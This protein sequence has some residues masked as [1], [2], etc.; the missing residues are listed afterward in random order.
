[1]KRYF[2]KILL[3]IMLL[4]TIGTIQE[5]DFKFV[6]DIKTI[7]NNLF[8][9]N[10]YNPNVLVLNEIEEN[11]TLGANEAV[12]VDKLPTEEGVLDKPIKLYVMEKYNVYNT[13]ST[14][15]F[16][17]GNTNKIFE[18]PKCSEIYV[19]EIKRVRKIMSTE[20]WYKISDIAEY[21]VKMSDAYASPTI[22]ESCYDEEGNASIQTTT[23]P[24]PTFEVSNETFPEEPYQKMYI[25]KLG[26]IVATVK[27]IKYL[28]DE[29]LINF[30]IKIK[31]GEEEVSGKFNISSA[32]P[33]SD[34]TVEFEIDMKEGEKYNKGNYTIEINYGDVMNSTP[35]SLSD[36]FYFF[37]VDFFGDSNPYY[38]DMNEWKIVVKDTDNFEK[39]QIKDIDVSVEEYY[40]Y[41]GYSGWMDSS[42]FTFELNDDGWSVFNKDGL[43]QAAATK[44]RI[45]VEYIN[46]DT[47]DSRDEPLRY[48]Y[49]FSMKEPDYDTSK[50]ET[51]MHRYV[52][53]STTKTYSNTITRVIIQPGSNYIVYND[54]TTERRDSYNDFT[55]T[56]T[57]VT[58][59]EN[60]LQDEKMPSGT[61]YSF[62]Y[63]NRGRI[64]Y[65][66]D[67]IW[68][69]K[70]IEG[71]SV[72][73]YYIDPTTLGDSVAGERVIEMKDVPMAD[74]IANYG[75][76]SSAIATNPYYTIT[77]TGTVNFLNSGTAT[78]TTK[79][80]NT[81]ENKAILAS[82]GGKVILDAEVNIQKK[83]LYGATL[84]IIDSQGND[85]TN[86]AEFLDLK[87]EITEE[88]EE[89]YGKRKTI[90]AKKLRISFIVLGRDGIEGDYKALIKFQGKAISF[91]FEI[92]KSTIDF[93][94]RAQRDF[95]DGFDRPIPG[96][97]KREW[98]LGIFLS[99]GSDNKIHRNADTVSPR[100]YNRRVDIG[101]N[102]EMI[103]YNLR[104]YQINITK[105]TSST[106]SY[107]PIIDNVQ[108]EEKTDESYSEFRRK[109][110]EA[111]E[112]ID[113]GTVTFDAEGNAN[114]DNPVHFVI[115]GKDFAIS[116]LYFDTTENI[117]KL[118]FTVDGQHFDIAYTE[119]VR[120]YSGLSLIIYN[121]VSFDRDGKALG[122]SVRGSYKEIVDDGKEVTDL[123]N[124]VSHEEEATELNEERAVSITPKTEVPAGEYYA[125]IDYGSYRGLGYINN[126]AD[127]VYS[128]ESYPQLWG[129]NIHMAAFSYVDPVYSFNILNPTFSNEADDEKVMYN[130]VIGTASFNVYFNNTYDFKDTVIHKVYMC[131]GANCKD[132]RNT[133]I[134]VSTKFEANSIDN[135]ENINNPDISQDDRYTT[136]TI[137]NK[138]K[139]IDNGTYI[140]ELIY[141]RVVDENAEEAEKYSIASA[142]QSFEISQ[143]YIGA[144]PS[145]ADDNEIFTYIE[146]SL[147]VDVEASYL[148]SNASI[149]PMIIDSRGGIYTGDLTSKTIKDLDGNVVFNFDYTIEPISTTESKYRYTIKN[150]A[151]AIDAGKYNLYFI[152][153]SNGRE[154]ETN[155]IEFEAITPVPTIDMSEPSEDY[156]STD[157][158]YIYI[159]KNITANFIADDEIDDIKYTVMHFE[160]NFA[161]VD[162]SSDNASNKYAYVSV[163]WDENSRTDT[164]I[165]GEMTIRL[166]RNKADLAAEVADYVIRAEHTGM[167]NP[168]MMTLPAFDN[169]FD[170]TVNREDITISGTYYDE[171]YSSKTNEFY[172]DMENLKIEV[173]LTT[174]Y[175]TNINWAITNSQECRSE[176]LGFGTLCNPNN[177]LNDYFTATN[178]TS[179]NGK[180]LLEYKS[181]SRKLSTG[182]YYLVL[183][184]E[185]NV[186]DRAIIPLT[187]NQKYMNID[188]DQYLVYSDAGNSTIDGLFQNKDG[189][190]YLPVIIT[191][192]SPSETTVQITDING[193]SLSNRPFTFDENTYNSRG[194]LDIKYRPNQ[195][196]ADAK[197]YMIIVSANE[198]SSVRR[199]MSFTMNSTYFNYSMG[200]ANYDPVDGLIPNS[201]TGGEA[202]FIVQTD[203]MSD[204]TEMRSRLP[205]N[206]TIKNSSGEDVTSKFNITS[207]SVSGSS[208]S[209]FLS[210]KYTKDSNIEPG[211]YQVSNNYTYGGYYL[212][213]TASFVIGSYD[214]N[215][216]IDDNIQIFSSTNDNRVHRNV[217]GTYRISYS[218][219]YDLSEGY[220]YIRITDSTGNDITDKFTHQ[221]TSSYIDVNY[222]ANPELEKGTYKVNVYYNEKGKVVSSSINIIL[223]TDFNSIVL[224]NMVSHPSSGNTL[225]YSDLD[226]Q[227]YSFNVNTSAIKVPNYTLVPE[228]LDSNG[229]D[230]TDKFSITDSG[231]SYN[232]TIKAFSAKVDTYSVRLYVLDENGDP[233]YSNALNFTIDENYYNL[234]ILSSSEI[235][236]INNYNDDTTSIYDKDGANV[237]YNFSTDYTGDKKISVI[238]FKDGEV[239]KEFSEYSDNTFN[240]NT[241][242]LDIGKYQVSICIN[243][244]PYDSKNMNVIEYIELEDIILTV[245]NAQI[246]TNNFDVNMGNNNF[247]IRI[248]PTNATASKYTISSS[249]T[250]ILNINGNRLVGV[251]DGT[252]N[253]VIKNAAIE[254]TYQVRVKQRLSSSVYEIDHNV[255]TIYVKTRTTKNFTKTEAAR[256]LSGLVSNY[257]ITNAQNQTVNTNLI[258]TGYHLVNGD[259]TYT[260]IVIGDV[261]GDGNI[262]I[263][264]VAWLYQKVRNKRK[265]NSYQ[266]KA[267][268]IRKATNINAVDIAWLYSFVNRKRNSI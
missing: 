172:E 111:A 211:V 235:K 46:N 233:N 92:G 37:D 96:N 105:K 151:R 215:I 169:L 48:T 214:K 66:Y 190:I 268:K 228:I 65:H 5:L 115:G 29:D 184:Y 126:A 108:L 230:V 68:V 239:I 176:Y 266:T 197:E 97:S 257:R 41:M 170:W 232:I 67:N 14:G 72:S 45:I 260:F 203:G 205:Q 186:E 193:N 138:E 98:F 110:P 32:L 53:S 60:T 143:M 250:S 200:V 103:F 247:T 147:A 82:T 168:A 11:T 81:N 31:Q 2:N 79:T 137:T 21:Y 1:M 261:T 244:I 254:K 140:Y 33:K 162:I 204:I 153:D 210:I 221:I 212:E 155:K 28:K 142:T 100:I 63:D 55:K 201:P 224:S 157:D 208:S 91:P 4:L 54:G 10:L 141:K 171:E 187:I 209:F 225:I 267:A 27:N 85:A 9:T 74:F 114:T 102:G 251:R 150:V 77:S 80:L 258:G 104:F 183:Y 118:D 248:V 177:N 262:N 213:K 263:M 226:G 198:N 25:N 202:F 89:G 253:L 109:Y 123:F 6:D 246:N 256:N 161:Y 56:Y 24:K 124:I 128:E 38:S 245:N 227:Y 222:N 119:A 106:I 73:Y 180:L 70:F 122:N 117:Q 259:T 88:K 139:N 76:I 175:R 7:S 59:S 242:Q 185:N 20:I 156:V 238:L 8:S 52:Y 71:T 192:I 219:N 207:R 152:F 264:D 36:A 87:F 255:R 18:L 229:K 159:L 174:P 149:V 220:M 107:V 75:D 146:D 252:T 83:Y 42:N 34:K 223:Y 121:N 22:P 196:I 191:G 86:R 199:S 178:T 40:D 216:I 101:E 189:H 127:A 30:E 43:E 90:Y 120:T 17:G 158:D 35:F 231:S 23:R 19:Y 195:Q 16:M 249:N 116:R 181:E 236:Q 57:S 49:E 61:N 39:E 194:L 167:E 131:T 99:D 134:D 58:V 144:V 62:Y 237:I 179:V 47:N 135:Y 12:E 145:F 165:S 112:Q 206:T 154:A 95:E 240:F 234:N 136:I 3:F 148:E 217:K 113:S 243:G 94:A 13:T 265:F 69:Y 164:S 125:Y 218:S 133:W 50:L 132:D 166:E 15:G 129:E 44:Y 78:I 26:K 130:N 51:T 160:D 188:F 182:E 173:P 64:L 84:S 93:Y 163:K 241:E